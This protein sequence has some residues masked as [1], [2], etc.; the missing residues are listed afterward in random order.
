MKIGRIVRIESQ[1]GAVG[2]IF[3]QNETEDKVK[4][5]DYSFGNFVKISVEGNQLIGIIIDTRAEDSEY[6][7]LSMRMNNDDQNNAFVPDLVDDRQIFVN[8]IIIGSFENGQAKHGIV[9][10]T[11]NLGS[12]IVKV[13]DE[14]FKKFHLSRGGEFM[15]GYYDLI[16]NS[17]NVLAK[18]VILKTLDKLA[19]VFSEEKMIIEMLK[20]DLDWQVK[21]KGY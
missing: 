6:A 19:L 10:Y 15:L 14:E 20:N 18:N 16:V 4:N 3:N 12:E 17:N 2:Q 5:N 11:P 21:M 8:I 1:I 13:S 7:R 9:D